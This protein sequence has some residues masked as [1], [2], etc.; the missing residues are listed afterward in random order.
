MPMPRIECR[1]REGLP[2]RTPGRRGYADPTSMPVCCRA[3]LSESRVHTDE[4]DVRSGGGVADRPA[5]HHVAARVPETATAHEVQRHEAVHANLFGEKSTP[6]RTSQAAPTTNWSRFSQGAP[7]DPAT[8]RLKSAETSIAP[9]PETSRYLASASKL[10]TLLA[11]N[12]GIP[13]LNVPGHT[14]MV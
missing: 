3:L 13:G 14:S 9:G 6:G 7:G 2:D 11:L 12:P 8:K 10:Y 5:R 1:L 4:E